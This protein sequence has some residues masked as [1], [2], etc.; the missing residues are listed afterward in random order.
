MN[1]IYKLDKSLNM[2]KRNK[3]YFKFISYTDNY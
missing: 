1:S 3:R 2:I